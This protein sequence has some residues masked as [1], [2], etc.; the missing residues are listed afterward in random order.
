L[1]LKINGNRGTQQEI[2][3]P[4]KASKEIVPFQQKFPI[5]ERDAKND[6]IGHPESELDKK[7]RLPVLLGILLRLHPKTSESS[8]LRLRLRLR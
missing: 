2:S 1:A 6:S 4:T 5:L 7:I 8:R 3:V